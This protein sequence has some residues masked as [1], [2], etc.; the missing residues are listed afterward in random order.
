MNNFPKNE[1]IYPHQRESSGGPL[2]PDDLARD[3]AENPEAYNKALVEQHIKPFIAHYGLQLAENNEGQLE[4][5]SSRTIDDIIQA[6][7]KKT[8]HL[9]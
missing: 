5:S 7:I 9:D 1:H 6:L 8:A 2:S 3:V 4:V